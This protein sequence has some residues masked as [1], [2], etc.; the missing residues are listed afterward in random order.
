MA[1]V[2]VD[3]RKL[4]DVVKND[5]VKKA[6]CDELVKN[7]TNINTNGFVKKTDYDF[8]IN[9][10]KGEISSITGLATTA[11]LKGDKNKIPDVSDLVKKQIMIQK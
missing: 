2:P 4:S 7:V 8:K 5:V 11:A 1:P 10:I 3:L 6:E 9:G